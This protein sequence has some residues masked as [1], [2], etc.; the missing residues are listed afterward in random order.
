MKSFI[1]NKDKF[2]KLILFFIFLLALLLRFYQLGQV[3]NGVTNDEANFAY[4]AYLLSQT[5]KDQWGSFLPWQFKGFGDYRL[6]G[7]QY[8]IVPLVKIFSLEAW[9]IRL[10]A[11]F[12]GA[13][14]VLAVYFLIQALFKGRDFAP[15]LGLITGILLVFNPWHFALSRVVMEANVGLFFS[16]LSIYFYL[17]SEKS[18][19]SFFLAVVLAVLSFYTYYGYRVFL[20]LFLFYLSLKKPFLIKKNWQKKI[21]VLLIGVVLLLPAV[22]SLAGG[23]SARLRQVGFWQDKSLLAE[24]NSFRGDCRQKIGDFICRLFFNKPI[25]IIKQFFLNYFNHFSLTFLFFPQF[26]KGWGFIPPSGYFYLVNLIPFVL[27]FLLL[28]KNKEGRLVLVL[29]LLAPLADSL[30]GKGHFARSFALIIPL[31]IFTAFGWLAIFSFLKKKQKNIL[32]VLLAGSYCYFAAAFL[33]N[34]FIYYPL[35]HSRYF[36]YEYRPLFSYLKKVEKDYDQIFIS[37]VNHDTKQYIFYLYYFKVDSQQYFKMNKEIIVEDNGWLWVQKI[38]KF[39]F[40]N[41]AKKIEDYPPNSLLAID[42][43][44]VKDFPRPQ[45]V[46]KYPTGEAAFNIYDLDQTRIKIEKGGK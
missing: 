31:L 33:I 23:G 25:T 30:T 28:N 44:G 27:G 8:L 1:K 10:P 36:H 26:E 20:P 37:R 15:V 22:F 42:P 43:Q 38:G 46:I 11:A 2:S 34:Y 6:P 29:V 19:R 40:I 21:A 9:V 7:Y 39:N 13:A 17:R 16:L 12:F 35:R 14:T 41:Q 24:T 3:P 32:S 4:D 18:L 45:E 5:G